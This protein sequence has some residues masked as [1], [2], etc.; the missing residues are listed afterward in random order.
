MQEHAV[1]TGGASGIGLAVCTALRRQGAKVSMLDIAEE[2]RTAAEEIGAKFHLVNVTDAAEVE[3]IAQDLEAETPPT[4]L[5]TCAGNLQRTLPPAE[6]SWPEWDR[7]VA[8][9]QRGTYACCKSF[10]E[11]MAKRGAGSIVTISSVAGIAT[12]PLHAYGPSKAAIAHLSRCLAA[13]WGP[14][15]IRVNCIAPGFT[16]TQALAR[17]VEGG[18][19]TVDRLNNSAA[20]RR[21]VRADEIANAVLFLASPLASA[22]TGAVLPVDAGYLAANG[23]NAYG[24]LRE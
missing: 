7:T 2:G 18:A 13:E 1:V 23:W 3:R 4:I 5:V 9:H 12:G 22:V 6:L 24:G 21:L 16:E 19:L 15:G 10:G 14:Q 8:V 11:R 17:G 20:L